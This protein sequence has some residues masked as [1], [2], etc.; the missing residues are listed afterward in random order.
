MSA[1]VSPV[2]RD[3]P[4]YRLA[5]A[6]LRVVFE[7][8]FTT[9]VSG[10]EHVPPAGEP[11][12]LVANH[13]SGIDVFLAG[14]ALHR[15]ASFLAKV[16]A[17]RF[18]LFGRYLLALGAI[19]T[20]RD[21]QDTEALRRMMAALRAGGTAGLAPEGTRSPDGTLR[22]Y[23]PGFVWLASRTG[24][25]VLPCAIHGAYQLMPKEARLPRRGPLWVRFGP[26]L[27]FEAEGR[28]IP[29]ERMRAL[30]DEVRDR[31]LAMLADLVAETGVPHPAVGAGDG[32]C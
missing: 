4:A 20:N 11:T 15:P 1:A 29:R 17:T 27:S 18:P 22:A 6:L 8:Y 24:A 16:E 9:H 5:F 25:A 32:S 31:T 28:R 23:D 10:R 3:G 21:R 14:H 30:A 26:P 19:P 7:G 2:P 13:T 12:L